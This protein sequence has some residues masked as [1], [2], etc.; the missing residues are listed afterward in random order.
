MFEVFYFQGSP[1]LRPHF[2]YTYL[3]LFVGPSKSK[4]LQPDIYIGIFF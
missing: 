1:L 3:F 2:S 4:P